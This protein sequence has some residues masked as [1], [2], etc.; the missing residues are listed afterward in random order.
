MVAQSCTDGLVSLKGHKCGYGIIHK[1]FLLGHM[2]RAPHPSNR[3]YPT[4]LAKPFDLGPFEKVEKINTGYVNIWVVYEFWNTAVPFTA[5]KRP[6][7][8][9]CQKRTV[10]DDFRSSPVLDQPEEPGG[11]DLVHVVHFEG[12]QRQF[13]QLS[14][15]RVDP[16]INA[17]APAKFEL[18]RRV[19]IITF[20]R[21]FVDGVGNAVLDFKKGRQFEY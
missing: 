17:I 10:C 6:H 9:R 16:V 1:I 5:P 18:K 14:K 21:K 13:H 19:K 15:H 3:A 7:S 2:A 8:P 4:W 12:S 11:T 20:Q